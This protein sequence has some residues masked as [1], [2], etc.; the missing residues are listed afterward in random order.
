MITP[1][2]PA[3]HVPVK[4]ALLCLFVLLLN[5]PYLNKAA[6]QDT[7]VML[8]LAEDLRED[9]LHPYNSSLLR[10]R[11][12]PTR[13]YWNPPLYNYY[14]ALVREVRGDYTDRFINGVSTVFP[15]V[16][17]LC[18][19]L[20]ARRFTRW[21]LM[22]ALLAGAAPAFVIQSHNMMTDMPAVAF[23]LASLYAFL[24]GCEASSRGTPWL[25]ASGLLTGAATLTRFSGVA[26]L[27]LLFLYCILFRR[28]L[29]RAVV[30]L[31]A[32]LMPLALWEIIFYSLH[33]S[34]HPVLPGVI[35]F[36]P[37]MSPFLSFNGN[38]TALGGA[39]IITPAIWVVFLVHKELR[40][41]LAL[42]P[43]FLSPFLA[44]VEPIP[45]IS[46]VQGL[47][48]ILFI[49]FSWTGLSIVLAFIVRVAIQSV[50]F[51]RR[52]EV[53]SGELFIG[54]FFLLNFIGPAVALPFATP[55]Y[56]LMTGLPLAVFLVARAQEIRWRPMAV[57]AFL[58]S[59]ILLT[60]GL[61]LT[62]ATHDYIAA[63]A[64][65]TFA[66]QVNSRMK[67]VPGNKRWF[68][69]ECGF[70]WYLEKYSKMTYFCNGISKPDPGDILVMPTN[71]ACH[72]PNDLQKNWR[73]LQWTITL[74]AA[75]P[76]VRLTDF[77]T[78][79][80]FY[81]NAYAPMPFTIAN[82]R[83]DKFSVW[84]YRSKAR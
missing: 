63:N 67:S 16:A 25:I 81:S 56:L 3:R 29:M 47:N 44:G 6:Y 26:V 69:A 74:P 76:P 38:C 14:L 78:G 59:T 75:G 22:C 42:S 2:P 30:A 31:V 5:F 36:L 62:L 83:L 19:Y 12:V 18:F 4:L 79:A 49:L 60:L 23:S 43:I 10:N 15:L 51:V 61:A 53:D 39:F 50:R 13:L 41:Y 46:D 37:R 70:R 54:W 20:I 66:R 58:G 82:N 8:H 64:L 11:V 72:P 7:W 24:R 84:R 33:G 77:Q 73:R 17:T 71:A 9:P 57:Q 21:P 65:R 48:L 27:P 34:L 28:P 80:G 45:H 55:R 32:F 35:D 1:V 40:L 68:V 52:R